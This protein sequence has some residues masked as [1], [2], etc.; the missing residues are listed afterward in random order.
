[1]DD[2]TL[3]ASIAK[4]KAIIAATEDAVLALTVGGVQ[5]Y[6]LNTGQTNQTVTKVNLPGL[7]KSLDE[8]YNRC[9]TME[10]RL[11]G[12]GNGIGGPAW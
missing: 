4:T 3:K 11:N 12:S 6:N 10:T 2:T 7:N 1:M 5:S 8:L 9:A